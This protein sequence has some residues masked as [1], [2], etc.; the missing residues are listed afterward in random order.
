MEIVEQSRK[1][2]AQNKMLD[3]QRAARRKVPRDRDR[4][5]TEEEMRGVNY[6]K[7]K[8]P[9]RKRDERCTDGH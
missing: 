6:G 9:K 8:R 4:L 2:K 5:E 1:I 7:S 3:T